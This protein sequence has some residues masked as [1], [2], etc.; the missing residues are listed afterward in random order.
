MERS[1]T[2]RFESEAALAIRPESGPLLDDFPG[3]PALTPAEYS[4]ATKQDAED[5]PHHPTLTLSELEEAQGEEYRA[6]DREALLLKL[7]HRSS[8]STVCLTA[9]SSFFATGVNSNG[10]AEAQVQGR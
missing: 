8:S 5:D 1:R 2:V 10:G 6:D 3:L 4:Q 9:C 7:T